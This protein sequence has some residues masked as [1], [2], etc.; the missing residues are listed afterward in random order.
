MQA[1][2]ENAS[3]ISKDGNRRPSLLILTR[4]NVP[5]LEGTSIEGT[6]KGGYIV[7]GDKAKQPDVILM[8]TG[9]EKLSTR[10]QLLVRGT[11]TQGPG[12]S[13]AVLL[14]S[15]QPAMGRCMIS[16]ADAKVTSASWSTAMLRISNA[17][18]RC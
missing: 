10:A 8:G 13:S 18:N 17:H 2:I 5:N 1:A 9:T 16:T 11:A 7:R 12:S 15:W 4:Q 14:P 6:T 3:G